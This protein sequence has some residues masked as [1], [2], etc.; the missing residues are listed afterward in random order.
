MKTFQVT[1]PMTLVIH[2]QASTKSAA[3]NKALKQVSGYSIRSY[4]P[5]E[6]EVKEIK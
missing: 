3:K 6:I 2:V 4:K 1:V 5:K